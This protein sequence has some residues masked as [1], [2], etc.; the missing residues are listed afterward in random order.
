[1]S[2]FDEFEDSNG[3]RIG[4]Q[5]LTPAGR[6]IIE[7]HLPKSFV[8]FWDETGVCGY[9]D[10]AFWFCDPSVY[11]AY[12]DNNVDLSGSFVIGR[13]AFADLFVWHQEAI[14]GYTP[15]TGQ[16]SELTPH[17][18]IYFN[19]MFSSTHARK[20]LLRHAEFRA[21]RARLGRAGADECYG[22]VPLP[23]LGGSGEPDTL[24]RV[25][26]LPYLEIVRQAA[27]A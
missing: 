7:G 11:Q 15:L 24:R 22:Y 3:P 14:Y 2:K 20:Y 18:E 27:P 8:D 26:I 25:K 21:A 19:K 6:K 9:V 12:A 4:C 1:M 13:N 17:V 10:G 16:K 23:A 5:P